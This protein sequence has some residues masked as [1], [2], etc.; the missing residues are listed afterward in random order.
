MSTIL[1]K[2]STFNLLNETAKSRNLSVDKLLEELVEM[3]SE[4]REEKFDA[5]RKYVRARYKELYKRLA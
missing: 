4:S 3:L 5:A 2:E 1:V